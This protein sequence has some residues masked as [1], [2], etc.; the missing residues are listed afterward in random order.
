MSPREIPQLIDLNE[1]A[2]PDDQ[3]A[4]ID[5]IAESEEPSDR[6]RAADPTESLWVSVDPRGRLVDVEISR[7]WS[8]RLEPDGFGD[9]LLGAYMAATRKALI[10]ETAGWAPPP[11]PR[12]RPEPVDEDVDPEVWL[13]RIRSQLDEVEE[14]LRTAQAGEVVAEEE[15]EIRG[16]NGYL[17]LRLRGGAPAGITAGPALA[18]ARRERLREDVLDIFTDAGLAG[19]L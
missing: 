15:S 1:L 10:V 6:Y 13:A 17:T 12:R 18:H 8:E 11:P 7:T 3:R 9:A 2:G 4:E 19:E 14:V 16:R 5:A